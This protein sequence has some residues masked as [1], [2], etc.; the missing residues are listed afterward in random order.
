MLEKTN[1][2]GAIVAHVIY[3]SSIMTFVA[4][5]FFNALP[6][7]WIGI[8]LLLMAFPL[9]YL[10]LTAPALHRPVLYYIQISL[11][12]SWILLLFL[13]DYVLKIEFRQTQWMVIGFVVWYFAGTGGM[14]G[15]ASQA[16]RGWM[17]SAVVLFTIAGVLAFAQRSVTGF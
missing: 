7:H 8:P 11:M 3:V 2:L 10:L 4:R 15:V 6:G 5:F 16:G 12:L 14:I 17:I 9:G 1:L 13:L